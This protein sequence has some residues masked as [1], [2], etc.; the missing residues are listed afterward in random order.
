MFAMNNLTELTPTTTIFTTLSTSDYENVLTTVT[1]E[2]HPLLNDIVQIVEQNGGDIYSQDK[3]GILVVFRPGQNNHAQQ[4]LKAA[5]SIMDKSAE[6]NNHRL[7]QGKSTLRIGIGVSTHPEQVENTLPPRPSDWNQN[8][9]FAQQLS[10]LNQQTPFHTVFA[11]GH[12]INALSYLN[13]YQVDPL[14][15]LQLNEQME[16]TPFYAVMHKNHHR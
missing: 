11:S 8:V 15:N 16:P 6:W 4:G 2:L 1:H 10:Q 12:T 9:H 3:Q 13:G 7:A 14:G 5:M